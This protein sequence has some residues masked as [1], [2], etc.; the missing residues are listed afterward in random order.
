VALIAKRVRVSTFEKD[1]DQKGPIDVKL[2]EVGAIKVD[3]NPVRL[4]DSEPKHFQECHHHRWND[5]IA[6]GLR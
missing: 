1:Q 3:R 6:H 2:P 4:L 5:P